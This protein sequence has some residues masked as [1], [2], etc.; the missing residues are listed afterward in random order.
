[1][2]NNWGKLDLRGGVVL[3]I[4]LQVRSAADSVDDDVYQ[5]RRAVVDVLRGLALSGETIS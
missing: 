5:V 3:T 4:F 1:M 2:A